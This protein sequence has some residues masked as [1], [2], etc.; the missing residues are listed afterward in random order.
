VGLEQGPLSL[1]STIEELLGWNSSSSGLEIREYALGDLLLWP[2]DTLYPQ[3][4]ALTSQTNG[5][6]LVDIV[7]WQAMEYIYL[8][9]EICEKF[10]FQNYIVMYWWLNARFVCVCD[11]L[12]FFLFI[13]LDIWIDNWIYR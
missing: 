9:F 1:V 12:C 3:K 13:P 5:G 6:H 8:L 7:G 2:L 10:E 4:L 11:I